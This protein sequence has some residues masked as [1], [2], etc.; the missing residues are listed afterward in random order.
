MVQPTLF[1]A[2]LL[3]G[4]LTLPWLV[5]GPDLTFA[6]DQ[7]PKAAPQS[8]A[9]KPKTEPKFH[10]AET[11]AKAKACFG[12]AP[13][14]DKL[15]PD[16][17]KPGAKV[18]IKGA[19]FGS[20]HCLRSVSFGPGQAAAFTMRNESTIQTTVPTIGRKGLVIV[21]VTTASGEDSKAFLVK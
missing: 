9:V 1:T 5:I 15:V 16:E 21:T 8:K 17:G 11:A 4:A 3:F 12:V 18:T 20:P 14:I 10:T 7:K 13:H 19:Q 6:E 2:A